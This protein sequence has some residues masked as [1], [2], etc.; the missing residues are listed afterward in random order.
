[1]LASGTSSGAIFLTNIVYGEQMKMVH[2]HN[3]TVTAP[4]IAEIAEG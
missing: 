1:M 2:G 4:L 3:E